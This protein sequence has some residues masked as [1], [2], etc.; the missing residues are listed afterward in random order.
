MNGE[1]ET[2][3]PATRLVRGVLGTGDG[4]RSIGDREGLLDVAVRGVMGVVPGSNDVRRLNLGGVT[5]CG[6][7]TERAGRGVRGSS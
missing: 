2:M 6:R 1:R 3:N 5:S 7:K 4:G